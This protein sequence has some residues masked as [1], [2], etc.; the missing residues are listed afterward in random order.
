MLT[1]EVTKKER[2]RCSACGRRTEVRDGEA[3]D[4]RPQYRCL[5]VRCGQTWTNGHR[6]ETWDTLPSPTRVATK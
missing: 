1:D 5:E 2:G 4:G 6:G 3:T